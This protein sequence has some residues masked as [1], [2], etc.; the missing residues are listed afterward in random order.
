MSTA[1]RGDKHGHMAADGHFF[2][3]SMTMG[4]EEAAIN[5]ALAGEAKLEGGHGSVHLWL[6]SARACATYRSCKDN[7]KKARQMIYSLLI[8]IYDAVEFFDQRLNI[9]FI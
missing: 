9:Y 4:G 5:L 2:L 8:L 3:A 6:G 1:A 7:L